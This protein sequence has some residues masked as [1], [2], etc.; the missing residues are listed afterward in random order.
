MSM[1]SRSQHTAFKAAPINDAVVLKAVL[2]HRA[3]HRSLN[4]FHSHDLQ[5]LRDLARQEG[6]CLV[7]NADALIDNLAVHHKEHHF[8][9]PQK[10]RRAE[11]MKPPTVVILTDTVPR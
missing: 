10:A 8:R 4:W 9:Y 11:L 3:V 1:L 5:K 2:E 6:L 7:P